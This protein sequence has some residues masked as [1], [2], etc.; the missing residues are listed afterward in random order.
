MT[1]CKK[2]FYPWVLFAAS[3]PNVWAIKVVTALSR[4]VG[5][6]TLENVVGTGML[7]VTLASTYLTGPDYYNLYL[8]SLF[9]TD[10]R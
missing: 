9:F 8:T 4:E 6:H 5:C 3:T 7:P 2:R 1:T 10:P